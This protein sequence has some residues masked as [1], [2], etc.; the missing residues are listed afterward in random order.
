MM[1]SAMKCINSSIVAASLLSGGGAFAAEAATTHGV[2]LLAQSGATKQKTVTLTNKQSVPATVNINF[3]ADSKINADDL[4]GFCTSPNGSNLNCQLTLKS[5]ESK[6]LPNASFKYVNM[7]LAFNALVGCNATKAEMTI[8]NPDWYDVLDVSVVD[9]FNEKIQMNVTP[10]GGQTTIL[11]PPN[12]KLGNQKVFG[13]FPYG[14][15]LCAAI[16]GPPCGNAGLEQCKG[17]TE[18]K[19]DVICQYQMNENT[20]AVEVILLPK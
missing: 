10:T 2:E 3:G 9:G 18:H 5:N 15:D 19:P 12:G 8:N 7:T 20:G 17:G 6:Q 11:G 1:I 4:K 14:C 13:V 16:K